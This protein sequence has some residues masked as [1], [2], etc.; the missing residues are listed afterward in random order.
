MGRRSKLGRELETLYRR[1]YERFFRVAIAVVGDEQT[2]HDVVQDGFARALRSADGYA[3]GSVEGWVWRI[4]VNAALAARSARLP[5]AEVG[6]DLP[7]PAGNGHLDE[8]GVRAWIAAL[9]ERQRLALFL[10][11]YADLDY[12]RIADA[13]GVEVGTV[14]ATLSAAHSTLRRSLKEVE[15]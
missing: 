10:R 14:S 15:R 5:V 3:G 13:L 11:Y 8:L 12:R 7:A 2:A 4:V 6:D 9:P 1:R